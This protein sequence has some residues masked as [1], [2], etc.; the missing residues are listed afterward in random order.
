MW[1]RAWRRSGR[2]RFRW[3]RRLMPRKTKEPGQALDV[4]YRTPFSVHARSQFL[5]IMHHRQLSAQR[6]RN[7][8]SISLPSPTPAD[9]VLGSW[10]LVLGSWFLVLGSWFLVLGGSWFLV[11]GGFILA[12]LRVAP[13][14]LV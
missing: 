8:K 1:D 13:V 3:P 5:L 11:L 7:D 14:W 9:L 12:L 10:F 2:G 6:A 4:S